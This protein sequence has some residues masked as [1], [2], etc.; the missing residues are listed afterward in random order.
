MAEQRYI[1]TVCGKDGRSAPKKYFT[2]NSFSECRECRSLRNRDIDFREHKKVLE[3]QQLTR[4][5]WK[6]TPG[7]AC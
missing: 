3:S 5:Y 4:V 6:S 7:V 2:R 1:C